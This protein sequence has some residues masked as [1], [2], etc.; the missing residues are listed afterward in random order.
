MKTKFITYALLIISAILISGCV[1]TSNSLPPNTVAFTA[2]LL[3]TG[4]TPSNASTA[5]GLA[6]FTY[7]STTYILT[8]IIEFEGFATA[9]TAAHIHKGAVGVNGSPVFTIEDTGPFTSPIS[10]TS[11]ALTTSQIADLMAGNYYVNIHT[12][13]YPDGEIRGQ[14]I[15]L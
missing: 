3:G 4:E 1:K 7:N 8:G 10:F 13:G 9:T 15:K 11:P 5:N 2:T 6:S 12:V 14:L